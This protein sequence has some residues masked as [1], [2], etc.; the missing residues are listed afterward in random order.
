MIHFHCACGI[1]SS[2]RLAQRSD[3]LVRVSR[4][5]GWSAV[6]RW[7]GHAQG[8]AAPRKGERHA[9]AGEGA[10]AS[11]RPPRRIAAPARF[12]ESR[13]AG[14]AGHSRLVPPRSHPLA[15]SGGSR[16]PKPGRGRIRVRGDSATGGWISRTQVEHF[17]H[18]PPPAAPRARTTR[19]NLPN[20]LHTTAGASAP[21]QRLAATYCEGG[22]RTRRPH[23]RENISGRRRDSPAG[24]EGTESTWLEIGK[25]EVLLRGQTRPG[26]P[27]PA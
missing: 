8:T 12:I 10:R 3:S 7:A 9:H 15:G 6:G 16:E 2:L 1:W 5:V 25:L 17:G 13:P 18:Q 19:R 20:C 23:K 22:G 14:R 26:K 4:R 21:S 24:R 27:P 11:R